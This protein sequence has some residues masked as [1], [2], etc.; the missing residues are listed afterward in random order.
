MLP[1]QSSA[2]CPKRLKRIVDLM[3]WKFARSKLALRPETRKSEMAARRHS[4]KRL[5]KVLKSAEE[6]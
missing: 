3:N 5:T 6:E 2:L 4:L 1:K